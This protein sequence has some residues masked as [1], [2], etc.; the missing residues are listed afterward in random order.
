M[1]FPT[2]MTTV[3]YLLGLSSPSAIAGLVIAVVV[4]AIQGMLRRWLAT[5]IKQ[6]VFVGMPS[7][8]NLDSASTVMLPPGCRRVKASSQHVSPSRVLCSS[9]CIALAV[10]ILSTSTTFHL[11][12][13][14]DECIVDALFAAIAQ[15]SPSNMTEAIIADSRDDEKHPKSTCGKVNHHTDNLSLFFGVVK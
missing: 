10:L 11:S 14:Q 15:A 7:L 2:P 8:T 5:H 6:K 13:T 3:Y 4:Y 12:S 1:F 9:V